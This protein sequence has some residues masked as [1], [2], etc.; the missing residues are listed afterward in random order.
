MPGSP[1]GNTEEE[2]VRDYL[3]QV[4]GA[5]LSNLRVGETG[6]ITILKTD[7]VIAAFAFAEADAFTIYHSAYEAFKIESERQSEWDRYDLAFVLCVSPK[8]DKLD[9]LASDIE[10]DVY[11]CRKFVVELVAPIG[12]ALARLPF[13]PL[14]PLDGPSLR[15]S[16][17]QTFLQ[18]SGVPAA[19]ARNIV[20]QHERGADRIIAEC[21]AGEFGQ[22]GKISRAQ[23]MTAVQADSSAVP[24]ELETLTIENFRAYRRP[25]TFQI[26]K[27]ITIL[28]GPNGF[29]KTSFFDAIDFGVTGMIGRLRISSDDHFKK[30]AAH[31]DSNPEDARVTLTYRAPSG[32]HTIVRT[33]AEARHAKLDGEKQDRKSVLKTLTAGGSSV[34]ERVDN[35]ISLFRATHLFSQD[36]Q[37]LT[38]NFSDDCSLPREIVSRMLAFE[39]YE[40]AVRKASSVVQILQKD[41]DTFSEEI[42]VA[43]TSLKEEKAEFSQ[44]RGTTKDKANIG[45]LNAEIAKLRAALTEIGVRVGRGTVDAAAVRGWRASLETR[46]A[47]SES[48]NARLSLLA[49]EMTSLPPAIKEASDLRARLAAS[50]VKRTVAEQTSEARQAELEATRKRIAEIAAQLA[51]AQTAIDNLKWVRRQGAV[52]RQLLAAA[53]AQE[54]KLNRGA[55]ELASIRSREMAAVGELERQ[56]AAITAANARLTAASDQL[57]KLGALRNNL[58]TWQASLGRL[59]EIDRSERASNEVL[60]TLREEEPS[61]QAQLDGVITQQNTLSPIIADA[62]R[63]Q[64][65][66]KQLLS[67]LQNHIIDGTCPLCGE[68]HGSQN[69]LVQSIQR[70]IKRDSASAARAELAVLRQRGEDLAR[71]IGANRQNQRNARAQL[72]ELRE[73]RTARDL[74]IRIF[75][76]QA[77]ALGRNIGSGLQELGSQIVTQLAIGREEIEE[78]SKAGQSASRATGEARSAVATLS[79]AATHEAAEQTA[80]KA[81]QDRIQRELTSLRGD[82]RAAGLS[83][84]ADNAELDRVESE[85]A[86]RMSVFRREH[87][88]ITAEAAQHREQLQA[89]ARAMAELAGELSSIRNRL[90]EIEQARAGILA[91]LVEAG[92]P[93]DSDEAEL[94]GHLSTET[95]M[96]ARLRALQES[97]ASIEVGLDAVTTAAAIT[98]LRDSIAKKDKLIAEKKAARESRRPWREYFASIQR[99]VLNEQAAAIANFTRQY[100]P[101]TSVIQRRLRSVY[102]FDDIEIDSHAAEITVAVKRHGVELRPVDYFSQSQQQTLLLGLFLTACSGQNW[103]SF[104]PVLLDDPVT[105]FDDLNTYALLDLIVGLLKS[106]FGNRQFI[107]STCDEKFFQLA[108]Q[109]FRYLNDGARFYRFRAV[110]EDGPVVEETLD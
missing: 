5:A 56:S 38:K 9:Q 29:G 58:R 69:E 65:E 94:I 62:D 24:V 102:G 45:A 10:T 15:P 21:I 20:V 61:L 32:T 31:L 11:F 35:L 17:A 16:S 106:D 66:L 83:M 48:R 68:D 19:L 46:I 36:S 7:R 33:V 1:R 6:T 43:A 92:L 14:T 60:I 104:A 99:L 77:A 25:Q 59:A 50:D 47:E 34:A 37:E 63:S 75:T 98:R 85:R 57:A 72:N 53:R 51:L 54:I 42:D 105:H 91:R 2:D 23:T 4:P 78:Y 70:Q 108:R 80:L 55:A 67:Q 44:L 84:D 13:L 82:P 41:I 109:K 28:Y 52:Y 76:N 30:V 93:E 27:E 18:R 87:A 74:E 3:Q 73:Q 107:I 81:E 86:D 8:L 12:H 110:G 89:S 103:S 26:G 96:Q 88:Q 90:S 95:R 39:D 22:A 97:V 79:S 40:N 100:G 71:Q 49:T 101:R 64:S